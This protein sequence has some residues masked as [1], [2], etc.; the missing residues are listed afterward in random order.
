MKRLLIIVITA[1]LGIIT[2]Y[3]CEK[4]KPELK[5]TGPDFIAF[6]DTLFSAE[7]NTSS[8][9]EIVVM[10]VSQAQ[11]SAVSVDVTIESKDAS[12]V[13]GVNYNIIQPTDGKITFAVGEYT[14]TIIVEVIDNGDEDGAKT[15]DF[16][17]TTAPTGFELG[18]PGPDA[19]AKSAKLVI[20][21]NDCAFIPLEFSGPISGVEFYPNVEF[22]TEAELS[23]VDSTETTYI[24]E[25]TNI[26]K[27]V[28]E[29]W[30]EVVDDPGE[31]TGS[32][33]NIA[34]LNFDFSDPIN[35][36]IYFD[37]QNLSTTNDGAW[38]YDIL[39]DPLITSKFSIC[40]KTIEL[41]YMINVSEPG[42]DY[43]ARSCYIKGEFLSE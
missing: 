19:L 30:G 39:N 34:I 17:L 41:Y 3:S 37:E 25:V 42:T 23:L 8:L 32:N 11:T 15:I 40:N 14:D 4:D 2:F 20:S 35:P 12:A 9:V 24:Y 13:E 21:D 33:G 28:Y 38:I 36:T 6:H 1:I 26:M 29:G 18:I 31:G 43:G 16:E 5:Y 27:A 10:M 7:E 22:A